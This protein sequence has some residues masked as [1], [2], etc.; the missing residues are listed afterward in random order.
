MTSNAVHPANPTA[1]SSMGL[2]APGCVVEQ[3]VL[4]ANGRRGE[5]TLRLKWLSKQ[6]F[7]GDHWCL[8]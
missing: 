2:G 4:F 1:T 8:S 7:S 6:N 5:L 3:H